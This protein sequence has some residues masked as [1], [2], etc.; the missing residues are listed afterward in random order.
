MAKLLYDWL[1]MNDSSQISQGYW[2][3]AVELY[4]QETM[5]PEQ[6]HRS[7]GFTNKLTERFIR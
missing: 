6:L 1:V 7:I 3:L 4:S 5:Q 2:F